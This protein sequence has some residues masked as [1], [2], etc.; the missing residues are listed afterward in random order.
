MWAAESSVPSTYSS[1]EMFQTTFKLTF[2]M[3]LWYFPVVVFKNTPVIQKGTV[4]LR[5][6]KINTNKWLIAA[7]TV[8]IPHVT[9]N[10]KQNFFLWSKATQTYHH[11]C[12]MPF[13]MTEKIHFSTL[14]IMKMSRRHRKTAFLFSIS[15]SAYCYKLV[16]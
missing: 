4:P 6:E 7:Y 2:N 16:I 5:N 12:N 8:H 9:V 13:H 1:H 15:C 14:K 11:G 3:K 10:D